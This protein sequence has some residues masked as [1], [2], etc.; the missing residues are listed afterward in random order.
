MEADG[1]KGTTSMAGEAAWT[2][3]DKCAVLVQAGRN[4]GIHAFPQNKLG[5]CMKPTVPERP[6]EE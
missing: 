5:L 6:E 4:K 2:R 3:S 1:S